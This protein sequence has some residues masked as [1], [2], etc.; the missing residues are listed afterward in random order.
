MWEG[1]VQI[2]K[3][4][5]NPED[6][7]RTNKSMH[8]LCKHHMYYHVVVIT[9]DGQQVQGII[10]DLDHKNVYMLVPQEMMPSEEET[11]GEQQSV[12]Q[13]QQQWYVGPRYRKYYRQIY[14]LATLT[15]VSLYP[16]HPPHPYYPY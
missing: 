10:T 11:Q 15:G 7:N 6:L 9:D 12:Q 1:V 5:A 14:T 4:E 8:Q 2:K 16:F 13:H 3:S